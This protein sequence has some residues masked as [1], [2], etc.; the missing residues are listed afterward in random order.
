MAKQITVNSESKSVTIALEKRGD[1]NLDISRSVSVTGVQNLS[2]GNNISLSNTTGN[3]TVSTTNNISVSGNI[4]ASRV[5][6]TTFVGN[7]QG[8][9]SGN[10]VVPGANTNII[11]NNNGNAGASANLAFDQ[12]TNLLSLL[13][14]AN[15]T[16]NVTANAVKTNNIL[17]ANGDPYVFV[18]NAAGNTSEIQFNNNNAFTADNTFTFNNTTKT[19]TAKN[20]NLEVINIS[21]IIVPNNANVNLGN[22]TNRFK[23]LYLSGNTIYLGNLTL[24]ETS[25]ALSLQD[26]TIS[27]NA[28]ITGNL[29]VSGTTIY[30]NVETLNIKDPIIEMGGTGNNSP[31]TT[32]DGKDRGEILHYY[33]TQPVD[34]F[35]GWDNSNAEFAFGSNVSMNNEVATFNQLGNVRAQ[36]VYANING[37]NVVGD[38]SGANHAN[39][40]DVANSVAGANVSGTVANATNAMPTQQTLQPLL[41]ALVVVMLV[42]KL[43][44]H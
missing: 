44:M 11:F 29:T 19:V 28:T 14:S 33:T 31:L 24:S 13:G 2:A 41:I 16:S 1:I 25:N 7:L 8:N 9:I 6:A 34:A 42:G 20:I 4:T 26:T 23:D 17:Y 10:I 21:N 40:A 3:I 43:V 27:G 32:N 15:I 35:M 5:T 22:S 30:A 39:I 18:T 12:D 36:H 37:S 38:V